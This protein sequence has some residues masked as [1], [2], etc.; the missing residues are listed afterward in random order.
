MHSV[1]VVVIGGGIVGLAA[2]YQLGRREPSLR[3]AVIE[4]EA[5]VA[6]HQSGRNSGVLHTGIY[7]KPGS[8]KAENCREGR[9]AMLD[10]CAS[11]GLP[12]QVC[13][14]VIVATREA[15]L[16]ALEHLYDRALANGVEARVIDAMEL[17]ELEPHAAGLR[18]IHV[19]GTGV[20]DFRAVCARLAERINEQGGTV[21]TRAEARGITS[22]RGGTVVHTT[23]GDF[24]GRDVLNCAGL[25]SD[26]VAAMTG[27][28]P[29]VRIVPFRGDYFSLQ[30]SAQHL[31]RHLIYPVPDPRFP[32]LGVHFT[33]G[34]DGE[35]ECGP[36]AVAALGREAYGRME[37]EPRDLLE[38]VGYG[39]FLRFA[40][41]HARVAATEVWRS[42]NRGSFLATAQQLVPQVG[43]KDLVP[44]RC[45]IRA[46]AVRP[47]GSL[48]D[49]FLINETRL[50]VHVL[51]APSP[52]ATS[53][54]N[55]GATLAERV[56]ARLAGG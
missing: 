7:Y 11:E 3:V 49:D 36:S 39:G 18:A 16:E 26:R 46:Q 2:A 10:F 25:H 51:N 50:A 13:G 47:D 55:I 9:Q 19:P 38:T 12:H 37:F 54:L 23:R 1:D 32:F 27:E 33:R 31:V 6:L 8:L 43:A 30:P 42:L 48:E 15:E 21:V 14:K 28:R 5:A 40:T 53:A 20:V 35:V 22:R 34:V 17:A 44:A 4:K 41:R 45:G 52:A 56:E 29:E 24:A